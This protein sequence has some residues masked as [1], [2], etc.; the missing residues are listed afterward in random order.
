MAAERRPG[1]CLVEDPDVA[2]EAP[3]G[4]R[5][6]RR[7]VRPTGCTHDDDLLG[8]PVQNPETS[9][10]GLGHEVGEDG[11]SRER[12]AGRLNDPV[13]EEASHHIVDEAIGI[14]DGPA[15]GILADGNVPTGRDVEHH[16]HA[17]PVSAEGDQ[18]DPA[19][20][21]NGGVGLEQTEVQGQDA[22]GAGNVGHG[23][24]AGRSGMGE[25]F[26]RATL[27]PRRPVRVDARGDRIHRDAEQDT[28]PRR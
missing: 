16:R 27:E 21:V 17:C 7:L 1:P 19:C 24:R 23:P 6:V 15:D 2:D 5:L 11:L 10:V 4:S 13:I 3:T 25:Q 14:V 22:R 20:P 18:V 8:C 28:Y 9:S 26:S 12:A